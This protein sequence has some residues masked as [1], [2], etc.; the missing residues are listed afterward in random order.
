MPVSQHTQQHR[1][2]RQRRVA[3]FIEKQDRILRLGEQARAR[4]LRAA[5]SLPVPVSFSSST[6]DSVAATC[7]F[8]IGL[9]H[10]MVIK[11]ITFF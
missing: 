2:H 11:L 8:S 3:D 7:R 4:R 9:R 6:V 1:L 5:T 10:E